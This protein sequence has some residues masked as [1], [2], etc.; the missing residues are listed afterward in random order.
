M[1][2]AEVL[3]DRERVL[4]LEYGA[5]HPPHALSGEDLE[6]EDPRD[7]RHWVR[8]YSELVDFVHSLAQNESPEPV[9]GEAQD[10][11]SLP[12]DVRAMTLQVRVLELHLAYWTERLRRLGRGCDPSRGE[13]N[14]EQKS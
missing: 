11:G 14:G 12:P 1:D 2:P 5:S 3:R 4:A 13:I 9:D 7:A 10:A 8:V 6:C